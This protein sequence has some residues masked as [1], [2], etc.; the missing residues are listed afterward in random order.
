MFP[1]NWCIIVATIWQLCLLSVEEIW[2]LHSTVNV[3]F[4]LSNIKALIFNRCF[5]LLCI[6][7][8][9]WSHVGTF[10]FSLVWFLW[11]LTFNIFLVSQLIVSSSFFATSYQFIILSGKD[12]LFS[13]IANYNHPFMMFTPINFPRGSFCWGA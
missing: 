3:I 6:S 2:Q 8:L 13:E 9:S 1:S 7:K 4:Y 10:L 5:A 11:N 12:I